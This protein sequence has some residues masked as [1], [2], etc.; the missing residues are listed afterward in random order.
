MTTAYRTRDEA[1][2]AKPSKGK[3][4][5]VRRGG[6]EVCF[7]WA[8]RGTAARHLTRALGYT[9]AYDAP[10]KAN[11]NGEDGLAALLA[12]AEG[13]GKTKRRG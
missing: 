3:L 7:L 12:G 8:S 13:N 9:L 2:A 6:V 4:V 10:E 1:M 5:V 11:G